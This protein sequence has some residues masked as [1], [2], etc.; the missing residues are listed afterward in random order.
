[1]RGMTPD[2][3][4]AAN[5][6]TVAFLCGLC[7]VEELP[8]PFLMEVFGALGMSASGMRSHL[9]RAVA[10]GRL[11]SRRHGRTSTYA[12]AGAYLRRFRTVERSFGGPPSWEGAFDVVVYDIPETRRADRDALRAAAFDKGWASPRPGVLL[13]LHP[14][15][16]WADGADCSVGRLE[17]DLATA[18]DLDARA[19]PLRE[20]ADRIRALAE[21]IEDVRAHPEERDGSGTERSALLARIVAAHDLLSRSTYLWGRLP[22]LPAELLPADYPHAELAMIKRQ[23]EGPLMVEGAWAACRLLAEYRDP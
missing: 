9:S 18:R 15:G 21:H 1:M 13:G 10:D 20:T 6:A 7:Q 19:W 11:S 5:P 22:L 4:S 14:P 17:V 3:R 12:L 16:A 2:S 23:L 8:G